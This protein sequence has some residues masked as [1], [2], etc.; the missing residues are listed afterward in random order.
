MAIGIRLEDDD[1]ANGI[2]ED[3]T[4]DESVCRRHDKRKKRISLETTW[5]M[6]DGQLR[7]NDVANMKAKYNTM[8]P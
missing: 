4:E 7:T 8:V 1:G 6:K 3:W 5:S 2:I